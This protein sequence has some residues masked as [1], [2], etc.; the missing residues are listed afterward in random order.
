VQFK[1]LLVAAAAA[2]IGTT[3]QAGLVASNAGGNGTVIDTVNNSEW[4]RL[5]LTTGQ[6]VAEALT[7]FGGLGFTF[8]TQ[9]QLNEL[10]DEFFT[11][12]GGDPGTRA[13]GFV[14]LAAT[15]STAETA[16]NVLFGLTFGSNAGGG[17][18]ESLGFYDD[19][20]PGTNETWFGFNSNPTTNNSVSQQPASDIGV[21]LVR[22]N[23]APEPGSL[24]L[25]A[26]AGLALVGAG[27]KVRRG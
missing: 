2:L 7:A 23:A 3:A 9:T 24:L 10:L 6:T 20:N 18:R 26:M 12:N 17:V 14:T 11:I 22:A 5:D 4:L 8:A 21:F 1:P 19:A 16:W 15:T 25:V 13:G 27:R